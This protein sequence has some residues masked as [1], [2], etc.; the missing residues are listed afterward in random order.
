[1]KAPSWSRVTRDIKV[2][3]LPLFLEDQSR[4]EDGHF[5]WSYRVTIEN[6][7]GETVTL[8]T[9][10]WKIVNDRGAVQ[11]VRGAGVVGEQPTLKPGMRFEYTSGCALSTPSGFMGGAY[12]METEEGEAFNVI[13]PSFSLD[14]PHHIMRLQ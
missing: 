9:R 4:P 8:K 5:M 10:Y 1:M 3:V 6:S 11:E 12:Q 2:T 7:G 14:S 13:I